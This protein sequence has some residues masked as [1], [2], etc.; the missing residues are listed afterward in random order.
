M[1]A[2]CQENSGYAWENEILEFPVVLIKRQTMEIVDEFHRYCR[3]GLQPTFAH[4]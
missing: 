3:P 2:T 4:P 1:E